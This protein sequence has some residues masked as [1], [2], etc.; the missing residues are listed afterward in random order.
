MINGN[1]PTTSSCE[2]RFNIGEANNQTLSQFLF[3]HNQINSIHKTDVLD[4]DFLIKISSLSLKFPIE[5]M[6]EIKDKVQGRPTLV[7]CS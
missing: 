5:S 4:V 2:P 3:T 1:S 6:N 7:Q